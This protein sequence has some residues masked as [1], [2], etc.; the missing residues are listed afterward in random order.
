MK[1]RID[2]LKENLHTDLCIICHEIDEAA[3]M[4][5]GQIE[6]ATQLK[7]DLSEAE[8]VPNDYH[9]ELHKWSDSFYYRISKNIRHPSHDEAER[10]SYY[11]IYLLTRFERNAF[12]AEILSYLFDD[13]D[14]ISSASEIETKLSASYQYKLYTEDVPKILNNIK[15]DWNADKQQTF[16][17]TYNSV[18]HS[19][20][21]FS[22]IIKLLELKLE[23]TIKKINK[24]IKK[25]CD[26]YYNRSVL[27][28]GMFF[29]PGYDEI[30]FF[31]SPYQVEHF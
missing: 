25:L 17:D 18:Y 29:D 21:S 11:L 13:V 8:T 24:N 22:K 7:D 5:D 10:F 30:S 1:T 16:V 3:G 31:H 12:L 2:Y 26:F 27:K 28:E 14:T 15:N 4:Y 9:N 23:E 19:S 6:L 20:K